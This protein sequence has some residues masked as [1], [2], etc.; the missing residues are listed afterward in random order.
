MHSKTDITLAIDKSILDGMKTEAKIQALS[1]NAKINQILTKYVKFY[2]I[3]EAEKCLFFPHKSHSRMIKNLNLEAWI[4]EIKKRNLDQVQLLLKIN[5]I[6]PS[7]DNLEKY[8]FQS[9]FLWT[10]M[11]IWYKRWEDENGNT[12]FL[13]QHKYDIRWSK[14]GAEAFSDLLIKVLK[15]PPPKIELAEHHFI[16]RIPKILP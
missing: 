6:S 9:I 2:R 11:Y 3:C 7:L 15:I 1:L 5:K 14:M 8:W 10:G 4:D 13:F 16:I 12:A